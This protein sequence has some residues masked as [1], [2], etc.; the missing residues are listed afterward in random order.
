MRF[1]ILFEDKHSWFADEVNLYVYRKKI[2]DYF[3]KCLGLIT[4]VNNDSIYWS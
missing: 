1:E 3:S 2:V 4:W